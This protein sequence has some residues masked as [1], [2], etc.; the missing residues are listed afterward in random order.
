MKLFIFISIALMLAGFIPLIH[1]LC[2]DLADQR[3]T[4]TRDDQ[5]H[6]NWIRGLRRGR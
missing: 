3:K 5:T 2:R 1:D 4:Q 6:I